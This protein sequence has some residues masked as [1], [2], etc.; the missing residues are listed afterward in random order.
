MSYQMTAIMRRILKSLPLFFLAASPLCGAAESDAGDDSED[1]TAFLQDY[2]IEPVSGYPNSFFS[3][4]FTSKKTGAR[5]YQI[6]A[7][8]PEMYPVPRQAS[9]LKDPGWLRNL[10]K[11]YF[12]C[13]GI[14]AK[15]TSPEE[16]EDPDMCD[17]YCCEGECDDTVL[18]SNCQ[19]KQGS[20]EG[21]AVFDE[22]F[23]K[24]LLF[25]SRIP[26]EH[27]DL[28]WDYQ[29]GMPWLFEEENVSFCAQ[30]CISDEWPTDHPGKEALNAG[31]LIFPV[32]SYPPTYDSDGGGIGTSYIAKTYIKPGSDDHFGYM[33]Y[34]PDSISGEDLPARIKSFCHDRVS[35]S[36]NAGGFDFKNCSSWQRGREIRISGHMEKRSAPQSQCR[37]EQLY[38]FTFWSEGLPARDRDILMRET[39]FRIRNFRPDPESC[40]E[41][42]ITGY[43]QKKLPD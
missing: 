43:S 6:F 15:R 4:V 27:R 20:M 28:F 7:V 38:L 14:T 16:P 40:E 35:F 36:G 1:N 42:R 39:E 12:S 2:V 5:A 17:E 8:H 37:P 32:F 33:I 19:S 11:D 21:F 41:G 9:D 22:M 25:D 26:E 31:Y 30:D 34:G 29:E 13:P 18:F 23:Y 10:V 3:R 24:V